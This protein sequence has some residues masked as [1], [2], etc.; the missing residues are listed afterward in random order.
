MSVESP[1]RL[2]GLAAAQR[3]P[4]ATF[5]DRGGRMSR[6]DQTAVGEAYKAES[7]RAAIEPEPVDANGLAAAQ[8]EP[9]TVYGDTAALIS[10]RHYRFRSRLPR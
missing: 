1:E 4:L 10:R 8:R 6:P 2:D 5:A 7:P 9:V 3:G